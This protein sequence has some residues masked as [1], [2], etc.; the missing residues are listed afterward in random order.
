METSFDGSGYDRRLHITLLVCPFDY[1]LQ[2][3]IFLTHQ[4]NSHFFCLCELFMNI[5]YLLILPF[6]RP[7][8]ASLIEKIATD[9]SNILMNSTP[10]IDFDGLVGMEAH[11]ESMLCLDY[12]DDVD[13]LEYLAK[14][15]SEVRQELIIT[16]QD[17]KVCRIRDIF[18]SLTLP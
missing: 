11:M 9:I 8:E 16:N 1:Q 2:F 3:S 18:P 4:K 12:L 17:V 7:D 14:G 15:F 6:L 10:S 5:C 13:S